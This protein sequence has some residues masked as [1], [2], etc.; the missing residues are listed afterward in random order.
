[1]KFVLHFPETN[2]TADD[3][4]D[5]GDV[6]AVAVRAEQAG[7]SGLAFSEHPMPGARWLEAGGHQSLDPYVALGAAASVIDDAEVDDEPDGRAVPQPVPAREVR[8]DRRQS[9]RTGV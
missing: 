6:A 2:G 5:A 4:L 7:F 8:G 3:M 1:M 9:S